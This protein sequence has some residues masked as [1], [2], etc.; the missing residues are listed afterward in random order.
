[1]HTIRAVYLHATYDLQICIHMHR[2]ILAGYRV[3]GGCYQLLKY[4]PDPEWVITVGSGDWF[5]GVQDGSNLGGFEPVL[6]PLILAYLAS[7]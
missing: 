5:V 4:V 6:D 2:C 1:M 7:W 3:D